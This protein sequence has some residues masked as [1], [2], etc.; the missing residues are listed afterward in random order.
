MGENSSFHS[1]S[2]SIGENNENIASNLWS[3]SEVCEKIKRYGSVNSIEVVMNI[4]QLVIK[5]ES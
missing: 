2:S 5:S 4:S 3:L 1:N